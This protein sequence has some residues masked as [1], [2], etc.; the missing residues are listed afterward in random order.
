MRIRSVMRKTL[1]GFCSVAV[2]SAAALIG[3]AGAEA[4]TNAYVARSGANSVTVIDTAADA[5]RGTITA[6]NGPRGVAVSRDGSRAY[7]TNTASDSITVIDTSTNT[8]VGTIAV[9]DGPSGLA[10]TPDGT[11]LYVMVEGAS[12]QA[13]DT[14]LGTVVATIPV[15][16]GT[17]GGSIAITPDGT[18]AYVAWGGVSVIDTATNAVVH[19]FLTGTFSVSV[20]I[21]P[22][23][24][25]AYVATIFY[26]FDNPFGF[27]ASGGVVVVDTATD[28]AIKTIGL[29]AALPSSIALAPDGARGYVAI[30]S[31]WVNTGY[32]AGFLPGRSVAV[33][34]TSSGTVTGSTDV[35]KTA[36]AVAVT[37]DG[38]SVYVTI[39][40]TNSVVVIDTAT[41]AVAATI[42]VGGN[43]IGVAIVPNA[44]PV[45]VPTPLPAPAP[46]KVTVTIDIKPG[47]SPNTVSPGTPK[48]LVAV[49][50]LSTPTFDATTVDPATI[51]FGP[52]G[53][54]ASPV[55]VKKTVVDR[56]RVND[57]LVRFK[58]GD[59]GIRC[60]ATSAVLK[61]RTFSGV[62]IEG[63]DS[64]KTV[65]CK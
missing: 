45:T 11:R 28:T 9:G 38:S 35:G 37:P 26:N 10:V 50:I 47:A 51:R 24:T 62:L 48:E 15:L 64:I 57:L 18:R 53:T 19:S 2:L 6:G 32:G 31:T 12:V 65:N 14:T 59:T 16:G 27:G 25:R 44:P 1:A 30:Q 21:S 5:V 23:G 41:T 58:M 33:I 54:E 63:T 20:A 8:A 17:G 61:A 43:P 22:D 60:G 52:A 39:P 29:F 55:E 7:V 46:G 36:A 34:D 13:I 49:G 42:P 40:V 3:A 56:D 4:Q